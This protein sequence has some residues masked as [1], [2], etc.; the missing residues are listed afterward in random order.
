[1]KRILVVEDDTSIRELL[2]EILEGEGYLVSASK[3]GY[4]GIQ[5]LETYIPDLILMDVMMPIMDGYAFKNE[6]LL[7]SEWRSIPVVAMSAQVQ[8]KEKLA[9]YGI[10]NFISKPLDLGHLLETLKNISPV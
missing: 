6:L 3:N 8:R 7:N 10:V 9:D 2:V 5:S 1:M 4:E